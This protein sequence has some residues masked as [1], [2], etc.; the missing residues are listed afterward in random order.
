M[1]NRDSE[2]IFSSCLTRS[3]FTPPLQG[4]ASAPAVLFALSHCLLSTDYITY[5]PVALH[6]VN[7]PTYGKFWRAHSLYLL[8]HMRCQHESEQRCIC[9]SGNGGP[10]TSQ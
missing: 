6:S 2:P 9:V 4:V 10:L 1:G 8:H 7:V 5:M 3:R